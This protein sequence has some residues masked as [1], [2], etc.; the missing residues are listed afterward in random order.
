MNYDVDKMLLFIIVSR[1]VK[2][3][4][5]RLPCFEY[6]YIETHLVDKLVQGIEMNAHDVSVIRLTC[7]LSCFRANENGPCKGWF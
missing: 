2:I 6:R 1:L 7:R 3:S 4:N 5:V